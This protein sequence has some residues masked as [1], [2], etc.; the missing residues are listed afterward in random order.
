M[1]NPKQVY[2]ELA[3][4]HDLTTMHQVT[5][6]V[7]TPGSPFLDDWDY[8]RVVCLLPTDP[9]PAGHVYRAA[10]TGFAARSAPA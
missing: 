5:C 2:I 3:T 6:Y 9:L 8:R 10:V 7:Q 1:F 4:L